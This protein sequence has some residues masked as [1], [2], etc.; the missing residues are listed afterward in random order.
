M[1]IGER[2]FIA[3]HTGMV[4]SA[5]VRKFEREGFHDILTATR[6]D[7]DLT[8]EAQ[9]RRFLFKH[10]PDYVVLAAAKVGG[11]QA[12]IES[13]VEFLLQNLKIQNNVIMAAFEAKV[14]KFCFLGSSCIYPKDASQPIKEDSLLT[15]PLEPTNEGYAL[16]KITGLR[17]VQYLNRQY[18]FNGINVMPCNLYGKND[19]FDLRSCHVLSALVRRFSDAVV[20]GLDHV[21]LWGTGIARREFMHVDDLAA[22]VF[23]LLEIYDSPE[24]IN[25]GWGEDIAIHDL[26]TKISKV[27]GYQGKVLWDPTKP[28]GMLRKCMDVSRMKAHGFLPKI[29]LEAG[30]QLMKEE[31]QDFRSREKLK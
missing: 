18:G 7:V 8:D 24:V 23:H 6:D 2:V 26:A 20:S 15:G 12:N 10:R 1:K 27:V 30:L 28:D 19:S 9:V 13:P 5:L 16:A 29:G 31:Y 22:A 14:K 17:L 21:Q 25:V 4:G 11:I 3:G